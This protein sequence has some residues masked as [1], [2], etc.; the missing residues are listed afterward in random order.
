MNIASNEEEKNDEISAQFSPT[1]NT[2][3]P[4]TRINIRRKVTEKLQFKK[5]S[6]FKCSFLSCFRPTNKNKTE[7]KD[8]IK[9]FK[10]PNFMKIKEA[11]GLNSEDK[12]KI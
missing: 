6:S 9:W 7:E 5:N 11:A 4:S 12:H 10:H 2:F 3:S 8:E 1:Q